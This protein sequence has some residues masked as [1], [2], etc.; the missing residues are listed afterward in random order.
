M[1]CK[2]SPI[3]GKMQNMFGG[4]KSGKG[5]KHTRRLYIA[6]S[7]QK[8]QRPA[9]SRICDGLKVYINVVNLTCKFSYPFDLTHAPLE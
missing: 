5:M 8:L 6:I 4:S 7:L 1:R 3:T 2:V 9:K